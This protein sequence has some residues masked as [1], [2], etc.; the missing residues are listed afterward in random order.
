MEYIT[1]IQAVAES[2]VAII[3][4]GSFLW[5]GWKMLIQ[6]IKKIIK[7]QETLEKTINET[8]LPLINSLDKELSKNGGKSI[9]DQ[10]NRI[11]DAVSLAELR[12]KMI[13]SNL[14]TTGAYECDADGRCTWV[15]KAYAEMFGLTSEEAYGNGWLS[16]VDEAERIEVWKKWLE[17]IA[18]DIPY[19][20]EYTVF[21]HRNNTKFRVRTVA[22]A[23]KSVDRKIL[24]FYGTVIK[25]P[26]N[27]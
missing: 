18:L 2:V 19:E 22:V 11:D 10:I 12:S 24:G 7:T 26:S 21:N 8:V 25:L 14:I 5:G 13:A 17:S 3:A 6:P 1:V 16:S 9:K 23:H 4:I 27:S 20:T 15:N